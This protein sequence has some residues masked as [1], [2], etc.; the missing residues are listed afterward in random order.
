[1]TALEPAR[2]LP[3]LAVACPTCQAQPGDLCTSHSGTRLRRH[4]TH[5][6][7]RAAWAAAGEDGVR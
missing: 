5:E 6:L 1:M 7:R 4:N 3:Q 2:D